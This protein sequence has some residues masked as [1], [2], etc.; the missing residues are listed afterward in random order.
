MDSTKYISDIIEMFLLNCVL[1]FMSFIVIYSLL[2][3]CQCQLLQYIDIHIKA[4]V[5][6]HEA[7]L[8]L[9]FDAL[10]RSKCLQIAILRQNDNMTK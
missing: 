4:Y 3:L 2:L 9:I 5:N 6:L 8:N 10:S 1:L 7:I